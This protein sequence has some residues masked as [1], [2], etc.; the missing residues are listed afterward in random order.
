MPYPTNPMENK[1]T[2]VIATGCSGGH[3]TPALTLA[4]DLYPDHNVIFFAKNQQ[5]DR[6]ILKKSDISE[7]IFLNLINIPRKKF[8]LLPLF[9]IQFI[10]SII[11]SYTT[12]KHSRPQRVISTGS[13]IALPVVITAWWLKIPVDLYELNVTP[14]QAILWLKSLATKI[15]CC[16]ESTTELFSGCDTHLIPY[17]IRFKAA[18]VIK[19]K[20]ELYEK[21]YF[22]PARKTIFIFGGSQGSA[23]LNK[24]IKNIV[25]KGKNLNFQVIHQ[26]GN[27]STYDWK[28]F[29]IKHGIPAV[30][31]A[32]SNQIKEYYNLADLII[33]RAGAG[34]L[35]EI[36]FFKKKCIVIPLETKATNHQKDNALAY[37]EATPDLFSVIAQKD[38]NLDTV[39]R[40]LKQIET[41]GSV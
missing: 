36:S 13:Y 23:F 10:R 16:F 9:L 38:I 17:P 4:Q 2:V 3:I 28:S 27:H 29:Y 15:Y 14:G 40:S 20:N 35:A 21:N 19:S 31:F 7:G 24:F 37:A 34:A 33:T 11:V 5:L 22:D 6:D 41:Q 32:Y 18:D 26:V 30:T 39:R 25:S 8:W 1:K 12:L